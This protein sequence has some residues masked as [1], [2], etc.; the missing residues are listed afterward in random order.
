MNCHPS[1]R[2]GI[3]IL[4]LN[5]QQVLRFAQRMMYAHFSERRRET[6]CR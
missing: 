2:K 6:G 5:F 3:P 1:L 4:P